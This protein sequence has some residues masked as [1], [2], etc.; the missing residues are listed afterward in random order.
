MRFRSIGRTPFLPGGC[1]AALGVWLLAAS[2]SAHDFWIEPSTFRPSAGTELA[3]ALRVGQDFRGD[4]VPRNSR[5]ITRFALVSN[6][7][8]TPIPGFDGVEPAGIVRVTEPGILWIVY[9][10]GRTPVTLEPEKFERYL[11]EEG[12]EKIHVLRQRRGETGKPGREVFS[13]SV[14]S[15]LV[16]DAGSSKGF[17]RA[18]GLTLEI[19]LKKDPSALQPGGSLPMT[20]LYEGEPLEGALMTAMEHE[21]STQKIQ[22]R[23]DSR[24]QASLKIGRKGVWLIKAVQMIPAPAGVDADWE[25][26]WTSVTFEIP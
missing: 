1:V 25:S 23:T 6:A 22:S 8:E 13:R 9:R 19:V 4:P 3:V 11:A 7:A 18:L 14:K 16:A 10:S 24:G 2:A 20:L 15:L 26:I 5:L 17:D 21:N 12:L